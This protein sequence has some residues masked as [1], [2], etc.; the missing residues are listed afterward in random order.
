METTKKI[1]HVDNSEFFRKLVRTNLQAQGFEVESY[2]SAQEASLAI[3]SGF[4]DLVIMGLT[5]ADVEG[6]E[7]F[8][9]IVQ[10]YAGPVIV[11]SSDVNEEKEADLISKGAK[12]AINKS[13]PW[14]EK[15]KLH[16]AELK[17]G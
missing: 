15:L 16:L 8:H 6:H 9:R 7:F 1:I 17:Q 5:F 11:I 4:I 10:S 12:A 3:S 2:D 14:K 13:G